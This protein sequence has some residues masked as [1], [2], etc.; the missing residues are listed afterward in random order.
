M[1]PDPPI[2]IASWS[3]QAVWRKIQ[4]LGLQAAYHEDRAAQTFL[5]NVMAL[6]YIP[7]DDIEEMFNRLHEQANQND[8]LLNLLQYV[9][10]T[11]I[12][13]NR[14]DPTTWSAYRRNI[15]TNNDIEGWH[16]RINQQASNRH[17]LPFYELVKL[18]HKKAKT[19][20]LQVELVSQRK[21]TR[22]QRKQYLELQSHII[23]LWDRFDNDEIDVYRLLTECST[24]AVPSVCT[25]D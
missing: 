20:D 1:P 24:L 7:A 15:R 17:Q 18:L 4:Y 23:R 5:R 16:N 12:Y 2:K 6:P 21:L 10:K 19:V 3:L 8:S 22:I 13:A 25:S 9:R 14:W 11:W